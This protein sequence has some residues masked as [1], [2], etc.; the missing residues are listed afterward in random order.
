MEAYIRNQQI[1]DDNLDEPQPMSADRVSYPFMGRGDTQT[2][3]LEKDYMVKMDKYAPLSVGEPHADL[4][5][6]Y[7]VSDSPIQEIGNSGIGKFTRTYSVIPGVYGDGITFNGTGSWA[8]KEGGSTVWT[9]PGFN[10]VDAAF[11]LYWIDNVLEYPTTDTIKL[12]TQTRLSDGLRWTHNITSEYETA[13]VDYTFID[14]IGGLEHEKQYTSTIHSRGTDYIVVDRV[15]YE[16]VDGTTTIYYNWF[17]KPQ[18]KREPSQVVVPCV[19]MFRYYAEGVNVD[20][21][22]NVGVDAWEIIDENL[23]ATDTLSEV[24]TPSINEYNAMVTAGTWVVS[25]PAVSRRWMGNI[26][27]LEVIYVQVK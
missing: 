2:Y 8:Y 26:W 19:K 3:V 4:A 1:F 15:P 20:K 17:S 10:T 6:L 11:K 14:N 18:V 12:Y 22:E 24:T 25:E 9:R 16:A 13:T 21:I 23:N 5:E 27:E 7:F